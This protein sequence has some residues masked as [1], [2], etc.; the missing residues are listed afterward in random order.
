MNLA[1]GFN[2]SDRSRPALHEVIIT[3]ATTAASPFVCLREAID[4]D[5][6]E[7]VISICEGLAID[8]D[9]VVRE[10]LAVALLRT[11]D[12]RRVASL[13]SS[14]AA[15]SLYRQEQF[16][17][18]L[19]A[20]DDTL[21]GQHVVAQSLHRL[22]SG[23]ALPRYEAQATAIDHDH[24]E[25]EEVITN[26]LAV[27]LA[28][29]TPVPTNMDGYKI[30]HVAQSLINLARQVDYPYPYELAYNLGTWYVLTGHAVPGRALLDSA[31]FH[32]PEG[33]DKTRIQSQLQWCQ[34]YSTPNTHDTTRNTNIPTALT[35]LHKRTPLLQR[36]LVHYNR[37]VQAIGDR[38][39]NVVKESCHALKNEGKDDPYWL[40]LATLVESYSSVAQQNVTDA[41]QLL[42]QQLIWLKQ[43]PTN[44]SVDHAMTIMLLH[45][46]T[47]QGSHHDM[48]Q[49]LQSLP[50]SIQTKPAVVATRLK[51]ACSDGNDYNKK[52]CDWL[53][54]QHQP[55]LVLHYIQ[56]LT[57]MGEIE[58]ATMLWNDLNMDISTL[59]QQP[60]NGQE[61]EY[62][63]LPKVKST[64]ITSPT[65][66]KNKK[67]KESVMRQRAKR[68]ESYLLQS[69]NKA[70]VAHPEQ[71]IPKHE[72]SGGKRRQNKGNQGA[73]NGKDAAKLD[74][75]ARTTAG[76][77]NTT[78][79]GPSTANLVVVGGN[80]KRSSRKRR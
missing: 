7:D 2:E 4:A 59:L 3:M 62:A 6:Y 41:L 60:C 53:K 15:Y 18:A 27:L 47:I 5:A 36:Q 78:T 17:P 76:T 56:A 52:A 73:G 74:I 63:P 55:A 9:V 67:S 19:A 57:Q 14:R 44:D 24:E 34:Q 29:S 65:L 42:D 58:A 70:S 66:P 40:T 35:D 75:A 69:T 21:L 54:Q 72:R 30:I 50:Q 12:F 26:A 39:F 68:R 32:A 45:S 61:L 71:W 64:I 31:L 46:A 10:T 16:A 43:L 37:A 33:P 23:E 11:S 25:R 48:E 80:E 22:N 51:M 49:V 1:S 38:K 8:D 20:A 77:F 13:Q 28:H 79:G